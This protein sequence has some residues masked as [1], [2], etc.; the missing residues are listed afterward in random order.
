MGKKTTVV[1][2]RKPPIKKPSI[3]EENRIRR[4]RLRYRKLARVYHEQMRKGS[5]FVVRALIR[6]K[7]NVNDIHLVKEAEKKM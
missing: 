6:H 5:I 4:V 1:A 3:A 2:S 7:M